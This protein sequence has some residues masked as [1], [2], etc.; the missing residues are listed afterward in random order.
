MNIERPHASQETIASIVEA[1]INSGL[2]VV[3][4]VGHADERLMKAILD[5][6]EDY[7]LSVMDEADYWQSYYRTWARSEG[8]DP[9]QEPP[10]WLKRVTFYFEGGPF[11][12]EILIRDWEWSELY[13][14]ECVES[15]GYYPPPRLLILFAEGTKYRI[16]WEEIPDIDH[17]MECGEKIPYE[18][19]VA[20][21]PQKNPFYQ[22]VESGALQIGTAIK[23][24]PH[25]EQ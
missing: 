17:R 6:G 25:G 11:Y 24:P 1:I 4:Y 13:R 16:P 8:C 5:L 18:E 22:W 21:I 3:H 20:D 15:I 14:Y 10:G 7:Q 12:K 9:P 2:K 23:I 19:R